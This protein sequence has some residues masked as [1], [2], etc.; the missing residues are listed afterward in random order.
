MTKTP[1]LA[2]K[3]RGHH[4]ETAGLDRIHVKIVN[5]MALYDKSHNAWS[6]GPLKD[7]LST[8]L[9]YIKTQQTVVTNKTQQKRKQQQ[10]DNAEIQSLQNELQEIKSKFDDLTQLISKTGATQRAMVDTVQTR[11]NTN[12]T[13][14]INSTAHM[15]TLIKMSVTDAITHILPGIISATLK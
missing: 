12:T 8:T 10:N 5:A 14:N 9:C 3:R 7:I 15:E 11:T 6:R 1:S 2:A 4:W 13:P